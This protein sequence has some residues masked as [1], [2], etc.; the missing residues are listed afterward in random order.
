MSKTLIARPNL[1][2]WS[3][4]QDAQKN[5]SETAQTAKTITSLQSRRHLPKS[6]TEAA[7]QARAY[8]EKRNA[9]APIRTDVERSTVAAE[10]RA[11][12][13]AWLERRRKSVKQ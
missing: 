12:T 1:P 3:S 11:Q 7:K 8:V 2:Y 13:I 5:S 10:A 4:A 9:L 6:E